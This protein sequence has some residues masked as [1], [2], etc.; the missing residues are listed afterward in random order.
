LEP[1]RVLSI[2]LLPQG[3]S[4]GLIIVRVGFGMTNA[5]APSFLSSNKTPAVVDNHRMIKLPRDAEGQVKSSG[6]DE[7]KVK[8]SD[9]TSKLT[10]L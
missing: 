2:R 3:I 5:G 8:M 4:Y 7:R 1:S 10:D 9:S 6:M